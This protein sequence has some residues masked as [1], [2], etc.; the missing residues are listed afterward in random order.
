MPTTYDTLSALQIPRRSTNTPVML[1]STKTPVF[2]E[3]M[4]TGIVRLP[5]ANSG[6]L[7]IHFTRPTGRVRV[8]KAAD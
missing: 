6:L 4:P 1:C 3:E 5:V 7:H 2:Y 8:S